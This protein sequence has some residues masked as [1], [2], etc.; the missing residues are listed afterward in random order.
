VVSWPSAE[1]TAV[2]ETSTRSCR[3]RSLPKSV[4]TNDSP[5]N[6]IDYF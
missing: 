3:R 2:R 5:E 4:D 1:T 6:Q